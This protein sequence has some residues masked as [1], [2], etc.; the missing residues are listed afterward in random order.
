M[1]FTWNVV[2]EGTEDAMRLLERL[3]VY[4]WDTANPDFGYNEEGG[5]HPSQI[6]YQL[7]KEHLKH[8]G[9]PWNKPISDEER[10]YLEFARDLDS[11][12]DAMHKL[13][14]IE[15]AISWLEANGGPDCYDFVENAAKEWNWAERLT[16]VSRR[17]PV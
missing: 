14:D 3:L 17:L 16:E 1:L 10:A 13:Y 9:P 15:G 5:S 4:E 6:R 12:T 2:A 11:Q 8:F 7:K